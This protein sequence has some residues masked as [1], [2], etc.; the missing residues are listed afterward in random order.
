MTQMH[1]II[2]DNKICGWTEDWLADSLNNEVKF[3]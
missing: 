3:K 1:W 2:L